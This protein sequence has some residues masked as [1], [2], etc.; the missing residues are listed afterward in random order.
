M[1]GS[2]PRGASMSN[3]HQQRRGA[4][5]PSPA[6]RAVAKPVLRFP[7]STQVQVHVAF[8]AAEKSQKPLA[9]VADEC[10]DP[11]ELAAEAAS[12]VGPAS[13]ALVPGKLAA[14]MHR[15]RVARRLV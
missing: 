7:T 1:H 2:F 5:I 6:L 9:G 10:G 11:E 3:D 12:P 14:F 13:T 15:T 8:N 4:D